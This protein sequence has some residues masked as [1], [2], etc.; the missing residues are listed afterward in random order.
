MEGTQLKCL[1]YRPTAISLLRVCVGAS[2]VSTGPMLI[3]TDQ[4]TY[5]AVRI[6]T[7][8]I[9][10]R[11]LLCWQGRDQDDGKDFPTTLLCI[12]TWK[13]HIEET[14]RLIEGKETPVH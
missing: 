1:D 3:A 12:A 7:I 4:L 8:I 13:T 14:H 11:K 10:P 9:G 5:L 6:G 2:S